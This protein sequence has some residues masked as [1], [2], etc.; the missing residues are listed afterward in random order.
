MVAL[1]ENPSSF[2]YYMEQSS[3]RLLIRHTSISYHTNCM[4]SSVILKE[5]NHWRL[6]V[7]NF[8]WTVETLTNVLNMLH[9]LVHQNMKSIT[10]SESFKRASNT[11]YPWWNTEITTEPYSIK[12][13]HH[14][15]ILNH[16]LISWQN[17]KQNLKHM[18]V[19]AAH[20]VLWW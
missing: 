8:E 9:T 7:N 20:I 14:L 3:L 15:L 1:K 16:I 12:T 11:C 18:K 5:R 6:S 2:M 10:E 19:L 17:M 4:T 13:L